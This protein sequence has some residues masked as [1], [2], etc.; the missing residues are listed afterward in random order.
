MRKKHDFFE[1]MATVRKEIADD[2]KRVKRRSREDP[3]TAGDEVEE[4]WAEVLRK[5]LPATYHV[6]TKGRILFEDRTS[7]PQ[8]DILVV[9]PS[10]P[11]ALRN[12]KYVFSGGVLAAFECKLTLRAR[13]LS[14]AFQNCAQIKRRARH[15]LGS[16]Q[17]ELCRLPIFG[18]LAHSH[19]IRSKSGES[20]L[21]EHIEKVQ[22]K[23]A[24]HLSEFVDTICVAEEATIPL[25]LDVLIGPN[26]DD[27][28][29]E[30]VEYLNGKEAIAAM[31][32]MHHEI[33]GDEISSG[34]VLA[35]FIHDL[36]R[37]LA[38]HDP[39]IRDWADHLSYLGLYGGIGKTIYATGDE[40]SKR[41][42]ER[43]RK[44]G[45]ENERWSKWSGTFP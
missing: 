25:T 37:R 24:E 27:A 44:N 7:S 9:K 8:V 35:G 11:L 45:T 39:L 29:R 15:V 5:W 36:T 33:D 43:L 21:Y 19:D 38:L 31:Y 17:D 40:L 1:L 3:G 32:T 13:D 41:V 18:V 28:L 42:V 30:D 14:D 10:Y 22:A 34:A 12:K 16:P 2:Y 4:Q 20:R 23:Y 6:I 26:I